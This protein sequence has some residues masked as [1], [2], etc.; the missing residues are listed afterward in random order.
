MIFRPTYLGSRPPIHI[1][2][3]YRV[4][5]VCAFSWFLNKLSENGAVY[6]Y[7]TSKWDLLER[8]SFCGQNVI[9]RFY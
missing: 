6:L 2:R 4:C 9:L 1:G 7:F 5:F 8:D 3:L